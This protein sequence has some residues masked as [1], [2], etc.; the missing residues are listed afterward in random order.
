[1]IF[2]KIYKGQIFLIQVVLQGEA[3]DFA[4]VKKKPSSILCPDDKD[5]KVLLATQNQH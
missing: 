1:M 5:T 4:A 2:R 3:F